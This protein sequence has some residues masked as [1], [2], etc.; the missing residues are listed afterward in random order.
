[1]ENTLTSKSL[2]NATAPASGK[3]AAKALSDLILANLEENS[4]QDTLTIDISEKSSVADFMIVTSG[5]SN[6]HVNA[7]ADYVINALKAE[8]IKDLGLSLIHI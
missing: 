2:A 4:A 8:G 7:L 1:M 3:D 6:R 5:R